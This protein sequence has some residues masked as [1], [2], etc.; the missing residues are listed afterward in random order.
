MFPLQDFIR[1]C[2]SRLFRRQ[3]ADSTGLDLSGGRLLT[4]ALITRRVLMRSGMVNDKDAMIGVL[5]PPSVAAVLAN[6][7]IGLAGKAVVNLNYTFTNERIAK[8]LA[9]C[10]ISHVITSRPFLKRRPY[11][12][13]AKLVCMED[14][15]HQATWW[16]KFVSGMAVYCLPSTLL[17]RMLGLHQT[18]AN[19]LMAV[20]FT[21]GTTADPKGV[22][23]SH[24]NM[25][26]SIDA[27]RRRYRVRPDDVVLGILPIFHA[28]GFS[29]TLWLPFGL[30]MAAV[31]H[32][33]PFG[34][35]AIGKLAK[36][37]LA[38]VLFATPTFLNVYQRRCQVDAFPAL[39]LAIVGGER[40]DPSTANSFA[41][42]FGVIPVEG[43]GTTELSPWA[44]VNVPVHRSF[45]PSQPFDRPGTVGRPVPGVQIRI[46][47]PETRAEVPTGDDGLLL[48]RGASVM[49]GYLH[50]PDKTA[51]VLVDG[52]Y[53]TGDFASV[54]EDE[55]VTI[56]GR[57]HRF[58]KIGGEIVPHAAV[59]EAME[60]LLRT[61][62]AN[63]ERQ[64]A[65]TSVPDLSRG[66]RLVVVHTPWGN[67]SATDIT[68]KLFE[69]K[70][71]PAV[72]IPK[73]VDFVE[74]ETIPLTSLGKIDLGELK[75]IAE[76]RN[77]DTGSKHTHAPGNS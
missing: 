35:K 60:E 45:A 43:Y 40:L 17:D 25:A 10:A 69:A 14:L 71:L 44:S 74:V 20:L 27:I 28:F 70:D 58:S 50:R 48:V 36:Q 61:N 26:A 49:L 7:G 31:Y 68:R 67:T 39:D 62:D 8:C 19:D 53:D 42:K 22:M 59:E 51:E 63:E 34:T 11:D 13:E 18:K 16:D 15:M 38:T 4:A 23:L 3:A 12:V 46:V 77:V 32:F 21:S 64:V 5:L 52:W 24:G 65:V 41:E 75:R 72:W 76:Q 37:Y 56:Q 73:P 29:A 9:E 57:Q 47:D 6:V 30:N 55:F 54:D 2:R 33:D 1:T 66:E